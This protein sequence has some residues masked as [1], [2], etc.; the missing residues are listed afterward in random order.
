MNPWLH[1]QLFIQFVIKNKV[2]FLL[3]SFGQYVSNQSQWMAF[4]ANGLWEELSIVQAMFSQASIV[5]LLLAFTAEGFCG[6]VTNHLTK[7]HVESE[8]FLSAQEPIQGGVYVN[9]STL[10]PLA[11]PA[12]FRYT[13]MFCQ[14]KYSSQTSS[15][16]GSCSEKNRSTSFSDKPIRSLLCTEDTRREVGE[17]RN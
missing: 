4:C 13:V 17:C 10:F 5:D 12:F 6:S 2:T 3:P 16:I 15:F 9:L 14:P 1:Y 11:K 8:D 7:R